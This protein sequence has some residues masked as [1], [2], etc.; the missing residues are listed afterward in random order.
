MNEYELVLRRGTIVTPEHVETGDI[1]IAEGKIVAIGNVTGSGREEVDARDLHVFAGFIDAHVHFNEP[2]RAE[3][4]GFATGSQALAA[5]GGTLF[6][7]MPLNSIPPTTTAPAF[8][9]KL[10]V[11][12]GRALVDFCLWGGLVPDNLSQLEA[13][14]E[15]GVIGFKA[16][17][18]DSGVT[19]FEPVNHKQ[20]REGMRRVAALQS[21]VAVHAEWPGLIKHPPLDRKTVRDFLESR[22]VKAEQEAIRVALDL[23]GETGCALHVVHVSAGSSIDLIADAKQKAVDVTCETCPH[24]LLFTDADMIKL[25]AVAKCAPPFRV[26]LERDLLWE[27]LAKGTISFVASDH[28]PAPWALKNKS[29]FFQVWGGISSCQHAFP[30]FLAEAHH[31]H[32]LDLKQICRWTSTNIADRFRLGNQK[33]RI[34][35][36]LDADLTV[37]RL[38]QEFTIHSRDLLYR[39]RHT[40]Y[41]GRTVRCRVLRTMVRGQHVFADGKIVSQPIGRFVKSKNNQR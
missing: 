37:A 33:G 36:G 2:G 14:H 24:Y 1:A 6:F 13:L 12:R 32:G 27:Q 11:A 29:D 16:F 28:S 35:V 20:L 18:V 22:P 3:W 34:A 25:G 4:E 21:I 8:D 10:A 40:P 9:Q 7:D 30:I 23:A 5:G 19:E 31:R 39:H 41:L 15:R 26:S 17:M 38:E